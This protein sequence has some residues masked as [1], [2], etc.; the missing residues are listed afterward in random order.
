VDKDDPAGPQ[1]TNPAN[2]PQFNNW[3]KAVQDWVQKNQW[4]T[5][6]TM[7]T[8]Y[9]NVHTKD[10]QPLITLSAPQAN[11]TLYSREG[12]AHIS[13]TAPRP[14]QRLEVRMDDIL[15]GT[16]YAAQ[17]TVAYHIPNSISKGYHDLTAVAVDDV[18]NQGTVKITV[19]LVA[20]SSPLKINIS[21]PTAG[22]VIK[23]AGFPINVTVL[24]N[25]LQNVQKLDL[26]VIQNGSV[27]LVGTIMNPTSFTN[28]MTWIASPEP[29]TAEIYPVAYFADNSSLKGDQVQV[30]IE[31]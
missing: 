19:N 22:T 30:T 21:S 5:T 7:P 31:Q 28:S 2:D 14:I 8:E 24:I 3:E 13:A 10:S 6:S 27:Q 25:D 20:D 9:D 18:G 29:G 26:F 16:A 12:T 17:G 1:P 4:H 23:R 11:D 15:I